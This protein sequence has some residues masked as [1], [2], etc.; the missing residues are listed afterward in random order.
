VGLGAGPERL[1]AVAL[2]RSA[3][4]VAAVLAV[5]KA[6]AAYLPVDPGYPADRIA[7]MLDDGAPGLLV[8]DRATSAGLPDA[9]GRAVVILDDSRVAAAVAGQPDG[10]LA[11]QERLA[12]LRLAHPAYVIYTSGS[13]GRP[14]GVVV[15]HG[16]VTSLLCW[17][18]ARFGGGNWRECSPRPRSASTCRSSRCREPSTPTEKI[19]CELFA[20]ILG[21]SGS[22]SMTA[23]STWAGT[24]C[25]PPYSSHGWKSSSA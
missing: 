18:A 8:S 15:Q 23:S 20:E 7:F 13:T 2:P 25:S 6:G 14:K 21:Q 24:H 9:A 17:A 1:V 4:M 11:D 12:P 19:V 22:G 10:A 3:E 16:S 5:A